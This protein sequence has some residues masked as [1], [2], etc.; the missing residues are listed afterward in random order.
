M[1]QE[2]RQEKKEKAEEGKGAQKK[3]REKSLDFLLNIP[4]DVT[5]ELGRTRMNIGDLLNLDK[6]AVIELDKEASEPLDIL[7]NDQPV[8]KGEVV[9]MEK[10]FGIRITDIITPAERV[11]RLK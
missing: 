6:G 8:A 2:E 9:V 1:G 10:R 7:V 3:S 5:V 4:L 11:E